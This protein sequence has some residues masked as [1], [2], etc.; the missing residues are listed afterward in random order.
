MVNFRVF[1]FFDSVYK[2]LLFLLS[3]MSCLIACTCT[4]TCSLENQDAKTVPS[5]VW[6]KIMSVLLSALL[7][8]SLGLRLGFFLFNSI[9]ACLSVSDF[10]GLDFMFLGFSRLIS[11]MDPTRSWAARWLRIG[12]SH[13]A[14]SVFSVY[15]VMSPYP[16]ETNTAALTSILL[17]SNVEA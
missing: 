14:I 9:K 8:I 7:L 6:I 1:F 12:M 16:L 10:V 2:Y 17:Y 5:L 4:C 13:A 11:V 3:V 15:F